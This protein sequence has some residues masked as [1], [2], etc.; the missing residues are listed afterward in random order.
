MTTPENEN[1]ET[2][3]PTE[4]E[5]LKDRA[6]KLGI[7]F[8]NNI[9]LDTLR[10]RVADKQE[11]KPDESAD[12]E[13]ALVAAAKKAIADANPVAQLA[14]QVNALTGETAN[15]PVATKTLR[16]HLYDE[17]MKLVRLRITCLDPKK[18]DLHGEIMTVANEYLGTVRKF[19]PFGEVT[20]EGYHVP[21]CL[22]K[23]LEARKFLNIIVRKDPRTKQTKVTQVWAR[24]FALD[25]LEP[26]S[27]QE[28]ER[29]AA[30]QIAA[31]STGD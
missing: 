17:Q 13:D 5:V 9:S 31:G 25:V 19:I 30:A 4:M 27:A 22:Y 16:Q 28:I 10:Q 14:T 29:L 26:L 12:E 7:T 20:D 23:M 15:A 6:R 18:K 24:E 8:S 2:R 1:T 3:E 21:Y 11:G